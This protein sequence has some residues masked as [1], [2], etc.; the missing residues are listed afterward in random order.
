M[1]IMLQLASALV[2]DLGINQKSAVRAAS[3]RTEAGLRSYPEEEPQVKQLT[4]EE[5]RAFLGLKYLNS[6]FVRT[7]IKFRSDTSLHVPQR[8]HVY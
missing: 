1:T 4:L 7:V 8:F 5:C 3:Y 2:I 6:A